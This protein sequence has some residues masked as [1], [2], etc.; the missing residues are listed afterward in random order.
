MKREIEFMGKRVDNG[1]W[2]YG[3]LIEENDNCYIFK[4][5]GVRP[6]GYSYLKSGGATVG[7]YVEVIPETVAQFLF[8]SNGHRFYE[9]CIIRREK[10]DQLWVIIW[11]EE[12][13]AFSSS[14]LTSA[15][16]LSFIL[17]MIPSASTACNSS[18]VISIES[19]SF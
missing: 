5:F 13:N 7:F 4:N 2:V 10:S 8:V 18:I 3:L 16:D 11:N 15:K 14:S 17:M 19:F 9:D 1:E 12:T 6:E